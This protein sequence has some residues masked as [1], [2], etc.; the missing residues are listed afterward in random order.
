MIVASTGRS[1][2]ALGEVAVNCYKQVAPTELRQSLFR[3]PLTQTPIGKNVKSA[4]WDWQLCLLPFRALA[5]PCS[6]F[7]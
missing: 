7:A 3:Q 5:F 1:Y 4:K 6:R 2:G